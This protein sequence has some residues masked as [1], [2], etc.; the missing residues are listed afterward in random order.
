[1]TYIKWT[2]MTDLYYQLWTSRKWIITGVQLAL[3]MKLG[4]VG[5]DP[6]PVNYVGSGAWYVLERLHYPNDPP[7]GPLLNGHT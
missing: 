7:P 5:P 3:K 2:S 4:E 6:R 1:M